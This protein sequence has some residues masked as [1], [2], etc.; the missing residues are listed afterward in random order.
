MTK[1]EEG[2]GE[3]KQNF[4][5]KT[6]GASVTK[7]YAAQVCTYCDWLWYHSPLDILISVCCQPFLMFVSQLNI[8]VEISQ[9][10]MIHYRPAI[11]LVCVYKL[12]CAV[13]SSDTLS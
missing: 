11:A 7:L 8:P 10:F 12:L 2:D 3:Y 13:C 1:P 9:C 6:S 5:S 4:D